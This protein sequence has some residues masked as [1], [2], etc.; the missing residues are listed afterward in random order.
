VGGN[1]LIWDHLVMVDFVAQK[2][3]LILEKTA[4]GLLE[5]VYSLFDLNAV[6]L[7]EAQLVDYIHEG[8]PMVIAGHVVV[9]RGLKLSLEQIEH[10]HLSDLFL[11]SLLFLFFAT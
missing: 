9:E 2:L 4:L 10:L 8:L 6:I 3:F 11:F 1:H 5:P 7:H